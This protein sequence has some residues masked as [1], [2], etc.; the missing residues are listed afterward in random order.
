MNCVYLCLLEQYC[1]QTWMFMRNVDF[2]YG[3]RK[4]YINKI[5]IWSLYSIVTSAMNILH[6]T[7]LLVVL[8]KGL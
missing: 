1:I 5:G 3:M 2:V 4:G 7:A 8:S 6:L